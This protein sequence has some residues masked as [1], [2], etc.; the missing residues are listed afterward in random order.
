MPAPLHINL[1][2]EEDETLRELSHANAVP[3]RTRMRSM[4]LRLNANG[5]KTP[6][7]ARY[8]DWHEHTVRATIRRWQTTG[9][10]GLWEASGR[11]RP[12]LWSEEDGQALEQWVSEPRRY[13]ARQLS[14]KL[15]MERKVNLG[16][17][18]VRRI[19]K[20]KTITGNASG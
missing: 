6:E 3:R 17:E 10:T 18:Q 9:L 1:T 13:S 20:K 4:A 8:L 16:S 14:H 2:P 7:I 15:A 19:L 11:G 12:C 5:W